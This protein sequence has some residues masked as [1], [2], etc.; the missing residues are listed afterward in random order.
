MARRPAIA[1]S[2]CP[3]MLAREPAMR[4]LE[5]WR[6]LEAGEIAEIAEI[7]GIED[8]L[9]ALAGRPMEARA[10]FLGAIAR[11]AEAGEPAVRAVAV[12]A[13]AGARGVPGVRAIVRGL[14]D[15]DEGVRRAAIAALRETARD[16]PMRYAHALFH[17]RAEVRREALVAVPRGATELAP[18]LRGDPAC[19]EAAAATPWP[20]EPL[21]L[22][23]DL[24]AAGAISDRE[25]LGAMAGTTAADLGVFIE[26]E[27][28]RGP[29][30]VDAYLEQVFA[31]GRWLP[32]PG[33]DPLDQVFA[34][35][36]GVAGARAGGEAGAAR[37]GG[38]AGAPEDARLTAV[39]EDGA[40][41]AAGARRRAVAAATAQI[42]E[43]TCK[44]RALVRRAAASLMAGFAQ[45]GGAPAHLIGLLCAF[46]PRV[47]ELASFDPAHAEAAAAGLFQL[48]WPVRVAPGHVERLLQGH[49]AG[50]D[51]RLAAALAGLFP[52][53]RLKTLAKIRGE[54]ALIDELLASDRGWDE[55]CGLPGEV[56]P[57]ELIWL[58]AI[59]A[60]SA[61]RYVELAG[62]ALAVIAG[63]RL[64]AFL[65]RIPGRHR[66][67]AFLCFT[68]RRELAPRAPVIATVSGLVATRLDRAALADVLEALLA[69]G[70]RGAALACELVRAVP[71]VTLAAVARGLSDPAAARMVAAADGPDALPRN[72]ELALAKAFTGRADPEI[73]AWVLR[74]SHQLVF[75]RFFAER[76]WR[77]TP[78]THCRKVVAEPLTA[79]ACQVSEL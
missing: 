29:D 37:A 77:H 46:E 71:L 50:A 48:R 5:L 13:L 27:R 40:E 62:R 55:L 41:E 34:A 42:V 69:G 73:R 43:A 70:A 16:A 25:L 3:V 52:A 21:P 10:P 15:D 63:K 47:L 1:A 6:R 72:R 4:D 11:L 45:R 54:R 75:A 53:Q 36:D 76:I 2:P 31:A 7:A 68:A 32:A 12:R 57:Q 35:I 67:G 64:E 49:L 74:V 61:E 22:A 23:F 78:I 66:A 33:M 79:Q 26:G 59:E 17:R 39:A 14:D 8:E 65:D 30:V 60:A 19:A 51:L 44:D 58:T 20:S 9:A 56:P 28:G 38:G 24:H 18:Y